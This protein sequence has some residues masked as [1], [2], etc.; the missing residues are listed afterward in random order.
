MELT[1]S[2]NQ[3]DI[4]VRLYE[5]NSP[6]PGT[7]LRWLSSAPRPPASVSGPPKRSR[8]ASG[9][10][11]SEKGDKTL[12]GQRHETYGQHVSSSI[13]HLGKGGGLFPYLCIYQNS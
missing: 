5:W 9:C 2:R 12:K 10:W 11:G 1:V 3:S 6:S 4:L 8:A 7:S 13:K